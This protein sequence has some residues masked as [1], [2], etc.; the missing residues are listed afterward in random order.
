M[1]R[2]I[3]SNKVDPRKLL[4][5]LKKKILIFFSGVPDSC[6]L[7]FCNQLLKTKKI[8]NIVA[9]N[10]GIAVSLGVGHFLATKK[11]PLHLSSKFRNRQCN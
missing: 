1:S 3:N 10:E 4:E 9:A 2:K 5:C 7:Q 11:N 8:K 6:T